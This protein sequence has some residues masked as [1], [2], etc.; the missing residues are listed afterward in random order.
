VY[1]HAYFMDY[2]TSRADYIAAFF[3]NINWEEVEATA[4]RLGM[5]KI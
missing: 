4:V 3:K 1:E 5:D 2:G